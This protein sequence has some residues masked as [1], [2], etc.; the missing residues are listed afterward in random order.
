MIPEDSQKRCRFPSASGQ[1]TPLDLRRR[2]QRAKPG[3][4]LARLRVQRALRGECPGFV[5]RGEGCR[6]GVP[7][8][9]GRVQ[10]ARR[11]AWGNQ[12]GPFS[13]Q[14]KSHRIYA[15]TKFSTHF[16]TGSI[17]MGHS[18]NTDSASH[19]VHFFTT[20]GEDRILS[21]A[22]ELT[23]ILKTTPSNFWFCGSGGAAV[24]FL[25]SQDHYSRISIQYRDGF[26]FYLRYSQFQNHRHVEGSTFIAVTSR[27]FSEPVSLWVA[28][29]YF[30]VA[31]SAFLPIAVAFRVLEHFFMT[32]ERSTLV[33][34]IPD[35]VPYEFED[36]YGDP[37]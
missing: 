36:I 10:S 4:F 12:P 1:E 6:G 33:D 37:Y 29:D 26:G 2:F 21:S 25:T 32:G 18:Q 23:Q 34:W 5:G 9:C 16:I 24:H 8:L 14:I 19:S 27:D 17:M 28:G 22:I 20:S 31:K 13:F 11:R 15:I 3:L 30:A 7:E 35:P